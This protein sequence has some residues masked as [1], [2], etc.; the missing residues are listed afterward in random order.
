MLGGHDGEAIA[1]LR[2]AERLS[3]QQVHNHPVIRQ[4]V[5]GMLERARRDTRARDLRGLAWRMGII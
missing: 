2:Q 3:P 5:T 1:E 4:Q